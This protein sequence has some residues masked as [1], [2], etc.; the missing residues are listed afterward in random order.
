MTD[1]DV[2]FKLPE[3]GENIDSASVVKVLVGVG[4]RIDKDQ[5][6]LELETDKA[7][8]EV[9]VPVG[10]VVREIHVQEGGKATVGQV[11][12]TLESASAPEEKMAEPAV[13]E[14]KKPSKEKK[15]AKEAKAAAAAP[16]APPP[17]A[18][19]RTSSPVPAGGSVQFRIPELGEN[20]ESATAVR[21]A[22]QVG[23]RVEKEQTL[24]ELE[25]DK[26]TIE[27]P[28]E[29]SGVIKAVNVKA[30]DKVTVGQVVLEFSDVALETAPAPVEEV[31]S[32]Q[33]LESRMRDAVAK[34][35]E[36]RTEVPEPGPIPTPFGLERSVRM[37]PAAPSVRRFAREIGV[38]IQQVQGT[39]PRGRISMEDVKRFSRKRSKEAATTAGTAALPPLPDFS[40][41]GEIERKPMTSIR[42][43]TAQNM[44]I[45]WNAVPRVTQYEKADITDLEEH[46]KKF[47][48]KVE[49]AGGKLTITAILLKVVASALKTFPQ[50]NASVD[51]ARQEI[52]YK[53]YC[54]IGVA[55]DTDRGLLVPVIRDADSKNILQLA[56]ELNEM[57]E[58]ARNRKLAL[59]EMQGGT[60]TITNLG[61]IGGT[62]FSPIVNY[63]EVA[64]LGISRSALEPVYID[65]R[66]E[67]RLM[68]PFSLSYDH[69]VI[70]GAAGARFVRWIAEALK[71]PFLLALEG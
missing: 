17:P 28:S 6:V 50:F 5:P 38:D 18:P 13:P 63:P 23:D 52:V 26:A 32:D 56:V 40:K 45:A 70:D 11:V 20:I 8:I 1:M 22:V 33:R 30:G 48:K 60:F 67:P 42:L 41:W 10:G 35:E 54:N 59:D 37:A 66:L 14:K 65:G 21:V 51:M 49:S 9:P 4:D 39:G 16:A 34:Q 19:A 31:T 25:T 47:G 12:L 55:V 29:I 15:A 7:T 27:V 71:D 46:R 61:G 69:R 44:S 43:K 62:A 58:K 3:L 2:E 53:K 36:P 68:M 24:L 64:I 57:A